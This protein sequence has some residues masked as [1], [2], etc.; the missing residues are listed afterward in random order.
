MA[1]VKDL[2]KEAVG[3]KS[4]KKTKNWDLYL[5]LF[6]AL[7][8]DDDYLSTYI[9]SVNSAGELIT[10][11]KKLAPEFRK[12]IARVIRKYTSMTEEEALEA[13][14]T[15]RL[16]LA[17][18][19]TLININSENIYLNTKECGK[20]VQLIHKP[21]L[22]T[23]FEVVHVPEAVRNNPRDDT[24]ETVISERDKAKTLTKIHKFQKETRIRKN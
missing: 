2:I 13:A 9:D 21:D 23:T 12:M 18:A 10:K 19:E 24:K 20:K 7:T 16:T 4:T 11:K 5:R 1:K 14:K 6:I 17:E 3:K 15:F 22:D 8:E